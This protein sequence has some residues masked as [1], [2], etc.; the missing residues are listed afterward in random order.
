M[1]ELNGNCAFADTGG[2]TLDGAVAD[3]PDDE[4][5]RHA[6]LEQRRI[7]FNGPA[8]RALA[9]AQEIGPGEDEAAGVALHQVAQ[10]VGAREGANIY[11]QALGRNAFG[12]FRGGKVNE[13]SSRAW[14]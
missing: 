4:D 6:G 5:S 3:V 10:P 7:A 14:A 8:L 11:E 1:N 2:D 9:I 13:I 12:L